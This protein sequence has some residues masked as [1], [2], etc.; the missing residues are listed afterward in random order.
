MT[1]QV[2]FDGEFWLP[3]DPT[4]K[5]SGVV[6]F[7]PTEG[8][9]LSLIGSFADIWDRINQRPV[10]NYQRIL[11]ETDRGGLTLDDCRRTFENPFGRRQ[12]FA[13]GKLLV[14]ALYEQSEQVELDRL[15]TQ[16]SDMVLW[17]LDAMP[18]SLGDS[19]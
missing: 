6:T 8:G 14:N 12:R 16:V 3:D 18:L 2:Q 15:V 10:P 7:S 1:G 4:G 17:L 9:V 11:G 13:V 19:A 5:I